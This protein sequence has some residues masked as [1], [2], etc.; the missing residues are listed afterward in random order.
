MSHHAAS[1]PAFLTA[2]RQAAG[3]RPGRMPLRFRS[4]GFP[5]PE[6]GNLPRSPSCTGR[7]QSHG[8]RWHLH[9]LFLMPCRSAPGPQSCIHLPAP[10]LCPHALRKYPPALW[11]TGLRSSFPS[12]HPDGRSRCAGPQPQPGGLPYTVRPRDNGPPAHSSKNSPRH[13]PR[14][15]PSKDGLFPPS[16]CRQTQPGSPSAQ[17]PPAPVPRRFRL[18]NHFHPY[19]YRAGIHHFLR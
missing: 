13:N 4:S 1:A 16:L 15:F 2:A 3:H 8:P 17:T 14:L 9:S 7:W 18:G 11:S 12:G 10:E 5:R 6:C 19:N